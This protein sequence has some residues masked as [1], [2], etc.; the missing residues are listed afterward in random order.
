[1]AKNAD[2]SNGA[3][4]RLQ[5]V[6]LSPTSNTRTS[7]ALTAGASP[8]VGPATAIP[9]TAVP[10]MIEAGDK[11]TFG[12]DSYV[13]TANV[14][15]SVGAVSIP[16]IVPTGKTVAANATGSYYAMRSLSADKVSI[17]SQGKDVEI[18]GFGDGLFGE[19]VKVMIDGSVSVSGTFSKADLGYSECLIPLASASTDQAYVIF[20]DDKGN[21]YTYE[22]RVIVSDFTYDMSFRDV[23]KY[24][25]TLKINGS[26]VIRDSTGTIVA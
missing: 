26:M 13:V 12:S 10:K 19:Y 21:G 17:K 5:L 25:G 7:Y 6:R 9:V 4:C 23:G 20:S 3:F 18:T 16:A 2:V 24:S 11:V 15:V 1:M 8:V 14:P 22:G